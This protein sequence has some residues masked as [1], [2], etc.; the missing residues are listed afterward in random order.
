MFDI[1]QPNA[2]DAGCQ[3]RDH[4]CQKQ[5]YVCEIY[6]NLDKVELVKNHPSFR[7][8]RIN[9]NFTNEIIGKVIEQSIYGSPIVEGKKQSIRAQWTPL[10]DTSPYGADIKYSWDA[11]K[12]TRWNQDIQ[13]EDEHRRFDEMLHYMQSTQ[14]NTKTVTNRTLKESSASPFILPGGMYCRIENEWRTRQNT[15]LSN[16]ST[17]NSKTRQRI[18]VK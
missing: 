18:N 8:S 9:P 12:S 14:Q 4:V 1:F 17:N 7:I 15:S 3:K 11:T 13:R 10:L 5:N 2:R 16:T 6:E